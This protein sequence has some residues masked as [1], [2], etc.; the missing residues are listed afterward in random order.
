MKDLTNGSPLKLMIAFAIPILIGNLFQQ[1]YN[2]IDTVIVGQTLGISNLAAVGS[3][4]PIVSLLIGFIFGMNNGFSVVI[5]RFFGANDQTQMRKAVAGTIVLGFLN[6]IILTIISILAIRPL[7]GLLHTPSGVIENAYSFVRIIILGMTFSMMY[8]MLSGILRALGDTKS[9]LYFLIIS[10]VVN[11]ILDYTFICGFKTGVE[12][13]AVATIISQ[14]LSA[15]LCF[16]YI[17]KNYPILRLKKEDFKLDISLV[18]EL[19]STAISMALMMSVV[20]MGTVIL[21][22]AINGFGTNTIAAHTAAR[23][24]SEMFMLP[25][26][27]LSVT[28]ATFSS[29]NFGANKPDRIKTGLKQIILIAWAW[30]TVVVI[31]SYTIVPLIISGITGTSQTEVIETATKYLRIDTPFYY[32]L[33]ILLILRS[34][35][36]GIRQKIVPVMASFIEFFGKIAAVYYLAP[37]FGY[38]GICIT[39]PIIWIACSLFLMIKGFEINRKNNLIADV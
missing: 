24:L 6:S 35:L 8:N 33:S 17:I 19:Y 1:M 37:K 20:A 36:Q 22:N 26:S 7:L 4:A 34:T 18:L 12:G 29:Q 31:L 32:V 14:L 23:K 39:E 16:I 5:A 21:Q 25:L 11:V 38:F 9:P 28:A 3:T 10:T 2:L 27:T 13:A 15:I 30:A